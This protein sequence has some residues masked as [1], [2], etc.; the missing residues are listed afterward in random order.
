[1]YHNHLILFHLLFNHRNGPEFAFNWE[2]SAKLTETASVYTLEEYFMR[3]IWYLFSLMIMGSMA[4]SACYAKVIR[5][6]TIA[7]LQTANY[8][9]D[10][11]L[12]VHPDIGSESRKISSE[13]YIAKVLKNFLSNKKATGFELDPKSQ[14]F[15]YKFVTDPKAKLMKWRE[16][17]GKTAGI[18]SKLRDLMD[19]DSIIFN[20][21]NARG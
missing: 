11:T 15:Y 8:S 19:K 12:L 3:Y 18:K 21:E 16:K 20:R 14:T 7:E 13:R 9:I 6:D 4:A 17:L 2:K 10:D 1:M 5:I